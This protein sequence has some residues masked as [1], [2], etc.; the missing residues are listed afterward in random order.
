MAPFIAKMMRLS[1]STPEKVAKK[2]LKVINSKNPPLRVPVTVDAY[3]FGLIRKL[4]PRKMYHAIMYYS[5]PRVFRWGED[6]HYFMDAEYERREAAKDLHAQNLQ[7]PEPS[8]IRRS[9]KME[10]SAQRSLEVLEGTN[11]SHAD[12]GA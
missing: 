11:T 4:L 12:K 1:P 7:L 6:E 3:F 2:I 5:L 10:W 9:T 8:P